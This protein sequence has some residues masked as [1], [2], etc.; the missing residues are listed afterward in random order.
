MELKLNSS[1]LL[2]CL[3]HIYGIIEV[4]HTLPILSNIILKTSENSLN[5]S[6]TNLDIYCTEK[7]KAE[8]T[9]NGETSVPA[10]TLFEIVK[11]LP[12]GSEVHFLY[13]DEKSLL[14][15]NC[16]RSKFKLSTM[17]TD[18]FP[19]INDNDLN[20]DFV[21]TAQELCRMIDKTKF[22]ISNED[23]RY[24]LN[25]IFIHKAEKDNI[26]LLRAVA[27]DGHRLAQYDIPLPQGAENIKGLI[28]PKKTIFE[29]R[30]SLDDAKNDINISINEN[31]IKVSY[32]NFKIISKVIDGTFPD[33]TKVVPK[34]NDK[35]FST[36]NSEL[37][38][39][40]DRVSAVAIN[41]EAKSK[42]I[43]LILRQNKLKL[44]VESQTKG[45]ADEEIDVSYNHEDV[46]IG[47]NSRY[48]IDICN[49][50]DGEEINLSILDSVSPA[51]IVDK[52]DENSF[53][54]LMPMR[55]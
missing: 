31:K 35:H 13:D 10:V 3:N 29:L 51:I 55:I 33:Y 28:V 36:K 39:A 18:D 19:T 50:I 12:S 43:K 44:S 37:K 16:G 46:E 38:N 1:D 27:T 11:R 45:F 8:V 40:I 42:A 6:S 22:A 17:K 34:N 9:V 26:S 15:L 23:A 32:D 53:F 52:S 5:L 49:E 4:R 7:I 47:F 25:G 30:K 24:Y 2:K 14:F 41:E 20:I 21:L 48:L 54:V